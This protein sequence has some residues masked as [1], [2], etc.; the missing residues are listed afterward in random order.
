[1][2]QKLLGSCG[3]ARLDCDKFC[4]TLLITAPPTECDNVHDCNSFEAK[5]LGSSA[6]G[7]RPFDKLRVFQMLATNTG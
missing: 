3:I 2:R 5:L 1:M 7:L 6:V 4:V